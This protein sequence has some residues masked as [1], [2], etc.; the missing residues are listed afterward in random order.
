MDCTAEAM[1]VQEILEALD[2]LNQRL[3]ALQ[4]LD[5][6]EEDAGALK[7]RLHDSMHRHRL[8]SLSHRTVI[9]EDFGMEE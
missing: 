1:I 4:T 2:G 9:I 6:E 3:S 8:S 7:R 5:Q